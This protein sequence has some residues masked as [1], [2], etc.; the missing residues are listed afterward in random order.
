MLLGAYFL[1]RIYV[2]NAPNA[3]QP[4]PHVEKPVEI[5]TEPSVEMVILETLEKQL[6]DLASDS[7]QE[8][9]EN[10][11]LRLFVDTAV[12]RKSIGFKNP[13]S[14]PIEVSGYY[15]QQGKFTNIEVSHKY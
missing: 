15:I 8:E 6:N 11:I 7:L 12:V 5:I 4:N 1:Y 13:V 10:E 9:L 2:T 14:E 3:S